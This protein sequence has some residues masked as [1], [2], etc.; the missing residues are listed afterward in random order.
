[1]AVEAHPQHPSAVQAGCTEQH[2]NAFRDWGVELYD[3]QTTCSTLAEAEKQGSLKNI[4]RCM[5]PTG[6]EP[7]SLAQ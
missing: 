2:P 7:L 3:W 5:M 1:M 4:C 6:A